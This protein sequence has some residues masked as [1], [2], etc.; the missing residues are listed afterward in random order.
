M[1]LTLQRLDPDR[2]R[3]RLRLLA[4]LADAKALRDRVQPRGA[5][6]DRLRELIARRRRLA[7]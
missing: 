3:R 2:R 1:A 5:R 6:T 4:E 7:G